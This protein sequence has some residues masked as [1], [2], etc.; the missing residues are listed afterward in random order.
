MYDSLDG[1]FATSRTTIA[2]K[3]VYEEDLDNYPFCP[4]LDE[5]ED[6]V[7]MSEYSNVWDR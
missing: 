6:L 1:P 2:E 3:L 7:M 5:N 4:A